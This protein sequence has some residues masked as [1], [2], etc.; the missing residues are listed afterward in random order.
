M[1][2]RTP[3]STSSELTVVMYIIYTNLSAKV[4]ALPSSQSASLNKV[5]IPA[6]NNTRIAN[7]LK[8]STSN[9]LLRE[10][11]ATLLLP[12]MRSNLIVSLRPIAVTSEQP[13][14]SNILPEFNVDHFR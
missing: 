4:Q 13:V 3:P 8:S 7:S 12:P 14:A 9:N 1:A 11:A 10:R 2:A 6:P 5:P